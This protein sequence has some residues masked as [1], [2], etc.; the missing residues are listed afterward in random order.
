M[1]ENILKAEVDA[2]YDDKKNLFN[3]VVRIIHS[4][5]NTKQILFS[6]NYLERED[7]F[8]IFAFDIAELLAVIGKTLRE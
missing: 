7:D 3:D 1:K 2:N 8:I 5:D 4:E 6:I